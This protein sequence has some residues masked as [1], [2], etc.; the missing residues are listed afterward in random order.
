[1]NKTEVKEEEEGSSKR[2]LINKIVNCIIKKSMIRTRKSRK[3]NKANVN[4][5]YEDLIY[6]YPKQS[7]CV[8]MRTTNSFM[9]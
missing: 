4:L 5:K 8:L 3:E 2:N 1:M 9:H 7:F 6:F